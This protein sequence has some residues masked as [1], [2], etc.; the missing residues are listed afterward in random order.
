VKQKSRGWL[1]GIL[2][3]LIFSGSMP[4][5]RVAVADFDPLFLTVARASIAGLIAMFVLTAS[6]QPRPTREEVLTLLAIALS[7]VIG[8][9][10]LTSLALTTI[11]ASQS[12]IYVGMLPVFTALFGFLRG[13]ERPHATFWWFTLGGSTLVVTWAAHNSGGSAVGNLLMCLAIIVCGFGY[14]EG[15][16]LSRRLGGWQV[17]CWALL[18]A[19]VPMLI[20]ALWLQPASYAMVDTAA[21]LGLTYVSLFSMLLGFVFWYRGLALGGIATV[22][23]LQLL[24]PF[25]GILIAAL[26]LGE[27]VT[28]SM[29]LVTAGAALCVAGV[30][31]FG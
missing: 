27:K 21:W 12:L 17:I 13:K 23:Q 29:L 28:L 31:R 3:M 10:L 4:A 24:Q 26:L 15:A 8:F 18:Y 6:R 7:V 11:T 9:P 25:V 30:R 1:N 16:L 14:A 5:T 20:L 2:G 19:L 22:G